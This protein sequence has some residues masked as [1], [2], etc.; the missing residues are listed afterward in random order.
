MS[1]SKAPDQSAQRSFMDRAGWVVEFFRGL[2]DLE[3]RSLM[4]PRMMPALYLLAIIAS[5]WAVISYAVEGFAMSRA[6]G[7]IRAL[8]IAPMG[9]VVLVTLARVALEL[10][11]VMFRI[12]VHINKMAGHTEEIA[13]GFPKITFWKSF[14]RKDE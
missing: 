14:K 3:F 4:T 1:K 10:C 6:Q 12:A 8:L 13:G 9:F 5:G 7:L 2:A 11:L